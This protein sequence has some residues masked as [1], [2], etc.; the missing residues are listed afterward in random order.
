MPRFPADRDTF[1]S[2]K[3]QCAVSFPS[4]SML[5]HPHPPLRDLCRCRT[6]ANGLL[7]STCGRRDLS[8][9][10]Y[11]R[12]PLANE[13]CLAL[14][15]SLQ[16]ILGS[17]ILPRRTSNLGNYWEVKGAHRHRRQ[18]EKGLTGDLNR[19]H[20]AR[21]DQDG[22]AIGDGGHE[23]A[24][25]SDEDATS[26]GEG[27]SSSS[28]EGSYD[29]DDLCAPRR[30]QPPPTDRTTPMTARDRACGAWVRGGVSSWLN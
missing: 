9:A 5:S 20:F 26:G 25:S 3:T 17:L 24:G 30:R 6:S 1:Y 16:P 2:E 4:L 10:N 22:R 12:P 29:S 28:S 15:P 23:T 13:L 27:S 18:T 19:S 8:Q 11:T 7:R 21:A 14:I